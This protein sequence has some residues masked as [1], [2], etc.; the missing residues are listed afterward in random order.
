MIFLAKKKDKLT[1]CWIKAVLVK[2]VPSKSK[3][4]FHVLLD[5]ENKCQDW[6]K[7]APQTKGP[8]SICYFH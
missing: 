4:G 5:S 6:M 2:Q 1:T 3:F 7:Q 8:G